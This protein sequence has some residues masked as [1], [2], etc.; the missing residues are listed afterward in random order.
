VPIC[1][2]SIT[3]PS[4][5]HRALFLDH[6][7]A[8]QRLLGDIKN[9]LGQFRFADRLR[10]VFPSK[11]TFSWRDLAGKTNGTFF[12]DRHELLLSSKGTCP[13]SLQMHRP[14]HCARV[15]KRKLHAFGEGPWPWRTCR[16][17]RAIN[18]YDNF[19]LF[20][21]FIWKL[22]S[23]ANRC[24]DRVAFRMNFSRSFD[25]R[26]GALFLDA[27]TRWYSG[28]D[29]RISLR[30]DKRD[31]GPKLGIRFGKDAPGPGMLGFELSVRSGQSR[32][33]RPTEKVRKKGY[34]IWLVCATHSSWLPA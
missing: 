1:A 6:L 8:D 18:G 10:D 17:R 34:G 26:S 3:P 25:R 21:D 16:S 12:C 7:A 24:E 15:D 22:P 2:P 31:I 11:N 19:F 29:F 23:G 20:F 4:F 28:S 27:N 13:S 32:G 30:F 33:R 14:I 5:Y 9:V